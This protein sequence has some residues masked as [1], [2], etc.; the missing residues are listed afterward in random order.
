MVIEVSEVTLPLVDVA[1]LGE[2][3]SMVTVLSAESV[4]PHPPPAVEVQAVMR[5]VAAYD[6]PF[7]AGMAA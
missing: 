3:L 5:A 6:A 7:G 2:V 1:S 4:V